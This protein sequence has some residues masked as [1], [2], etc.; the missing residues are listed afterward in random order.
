MS[1]P[2]PRFMAKS[3]NCLDPRGLV[4]YSKQQNGGPEK[5]EQV[6][7]PQEKD[8]QELINTFKLYQGSALISVSI[9]ICP[10]ITSR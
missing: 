3:M 2:D 5:A 9:W 6:E 7:S 10:N 8:Y 4:H 1:Q